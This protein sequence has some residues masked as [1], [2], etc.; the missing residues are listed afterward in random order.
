M[1]GR[2]RLAVPPVD[3][4]DDVAF[5]SLRQQVSAEWCTPQSVSSASL[6]KTESISPN[7]R[8]A[9]RRGSTPGKSPLFFTTPPVVGVGPIPDGTP[10]RDSLLPNG[11]S[12][13]SGVFL[14][15]FPEFGPNAALVGVEAVGSSVKSST[16]DE[17][18][19]LDVTT[20]NQSSDEFLPPQVHGTTTHK[21][22]LP[23]PSEALGESGQRARHG[24]NG[25]GEVHDPTKRS[26][27]T[28]LLYPASLADKACALSSAPDPVGAQSLAGEVTGT[29]F[30]SNRPQVLPMPK[31]VVDDDFGGLDVTTPNQSSDEFLPPQPHRNINLPGIPLRLSESD[32]SITHFLD[33]PLD[34][35]PE[36]STSLASSRFPSPATSFSAKSG[37]LLPTLAELGILHLAPPVPSHTFTPVPPPAATAT[38]MVSLSASNSQTEF[39]QPIV[40]PPLRR[41]TTSA[42]QTELQ[43]SP[44]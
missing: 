25:L 38:P 3:A 26:P 35:A 23:D 6:P 19:G 9:K 40:P 17:F 44:R 21:S 24:V 34:Y 29:T 32:S 20:P 33:P 42:P 18:G 28:G 41:N 2:L 1:S 4:L 43:S 39:D 13:R 11:T 5:T 36:V 16:D 10:G 12:G 14:S 31:S 8:S 30:H 37:Q 22:N 7:N 27:A 15:P